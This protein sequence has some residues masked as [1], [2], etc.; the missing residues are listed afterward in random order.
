M[1]RAFAAAAARLGVP[2]GKNAVFLE[3]G[4]ERT[5]PWSI[6]V[7]HLRRTVAEKRLSA[8]SGYRLLENG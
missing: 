2:S 8:R 6:Y 3:T 5:I 4:A 1:P 7:D